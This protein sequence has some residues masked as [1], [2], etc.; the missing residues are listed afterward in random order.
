MRYNFLL[1]R[2]YSFIYLPLFRLLQSA[3]SICKFSTT[4]CPPLDQGVMWSPCIWE[5]KGK[6]LGSD[7][8]SKKFEK[9]C[10]ILWDK[11]IY[12]YVTSQW[13]GS[14]DSK[15]AA[16]IAALSNADEVF[17]RVA[18][19]DWIRLLEEIRDKY[20]VG[21]VKVDQ[22]NMKPILYHFYCLSSIS[23]PDAQH[24]IDIDHIIPQTLFESS[25]IPNKDQVKNSIFNLGLLPK[26]ENC[27]KNAKRLIEIT[28]TWLIDQIE[29]YEFVKKDEFQMY[30]DINN[31]SEIYNERFGVFEK[32]FTDY[33][34]SLLNN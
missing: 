23:G 11:L 28:D 6:P 22:R 33:R 34:D 14:S 21:G 25:T 26:S 31:Y 15:I 1:Y 5:R 10:F 32:A 30:S 27:S 20:T 13:K 2:I 16:N 18:S 19:E 8:N 12:E 3:Q 9:N 7:A 4:V 29:K 24:N 17:L